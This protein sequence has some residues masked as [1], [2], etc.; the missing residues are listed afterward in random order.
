LPTQIQNH[1]HLQ[2][3]TAAAED[4]VFHVRH[5]TLDETPNIP[6]IM[7][8]AVTGKL[9]V[10]RL[11]DNTGALIQ[12]REDRFTLICTQAERDAALALAGQTM[13]YIPIYHPDN[14]ETA[15]HTAA[16]IKCVLTIRPG[17]VTNIDA[18]CQ[19][20]TVAIDLANDQAVP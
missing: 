18:S 12:F 6:V 16:R 8:R 19:Y 5:G 7:E 2:A 20:W 4:G 14:G 17:S 13:Y 3:L 11:L 1:I 15:N 10:H 9:H